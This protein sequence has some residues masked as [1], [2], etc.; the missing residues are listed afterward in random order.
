MHGLIPNMAKEPP[1]NT[2]L[3]PL[4]DELLLAWNDGYQV[5]LHNGIIQNVKAA[6]LCI[7][8]DIPASRKLCGFKG[9]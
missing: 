7:G 3:S 9:I 1:T 2:F 8:C 4:V 5:E 6:V